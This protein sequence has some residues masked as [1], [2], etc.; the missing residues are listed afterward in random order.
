MERARAKELIRELF[1][2]GPIQDQGDWINFSCPFAR[3]KHKNGTDSSPSAGLKVASSEQSFFNCFA[4]GTSGPLHEVVDRY[5]LLSGNDFDVDEIEREDGLLLVVPEWKG[6]KVVEEEKLQ[7]L[8][9]MSNFALYDRAESVPAAVEYLRSRRISRKACKKM[10][11]LF[12]PVGSSAIG[13]KKY[14]P[15]I[16]FPVFGRYKELY[17]F[18]GRAIQ[19]GVKL[20]VRDYAGLKKAKVL[21]GLH[22]VEDSDKYVVVVEGLFDYATL[23]SYWIPVVATMHAGITHDQ[24]MLLAQLGKPVYAFQDNDV[25]GRRGNQDIVDKLSEYLPV[26]IATQRNLPDGSTY[27]DASDLTEEEI[28][29]FLET[30]KLA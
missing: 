13:C 26:S 11:L 12:D 20:K 14:V 28:R 22:L 2:N 17:G 1:G 27:K 29:Y 23:V 5:N 3:W 21:L 10:D 19:E 9:R 7:V 4:C 24:A 8:D 16:L 30:A 15:R 25:A 18:S 6:S